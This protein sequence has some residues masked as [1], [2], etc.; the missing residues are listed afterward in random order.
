M[1]TLRSLL[2]PYFGVLNSLQELTRAAT[3]FSIIVAASDEVS[4]LATGDGKVT[5]RMPHA[6][7]ITEV[8]ASVVTSPVGAAISVDIERNGT[9][10]LNTPLTI[11]AGEKTS[12]TATTKV[13]INESLAAFNADD[14]IAINLDQVGSGTP[15]AGLK[16]TIKGYR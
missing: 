11:D 2:L 14:E 4:D 6:A 15:G 13:V 5:F 7:Q 9:S 12:V 10:I 16:V 8:L 3:E 1:P